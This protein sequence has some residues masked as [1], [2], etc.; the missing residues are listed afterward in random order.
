MTPTPVNLARSPASLRRLMPLIGGQTE[1][2]LAEHGFSDEEVADLIARK[3]AGRDATPCG[4]RGVF[5]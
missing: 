1:E 3:V 2:V 5:I 4:P